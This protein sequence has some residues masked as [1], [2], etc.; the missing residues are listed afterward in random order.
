[1]NVLYRGRDTS[2]GSYSAI[3]ENI[4]DNKKNTR[5]PNRTNADNVATRVHHEC[6]LITSLTTPARGEYSSLNT[7]HYCHI[8]YTIQRMT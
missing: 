3:H 2:T 4:F 7:T 6:V 5:C 8:I 1:M